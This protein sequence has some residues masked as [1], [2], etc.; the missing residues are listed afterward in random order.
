MQGLRSR[1]APDVF[2]KHVRI[3]IGNDYYYNYMLPKYQAQ[4][5]QATTIQLQNGQTEQQIG[6]SYKGAML[7]AAEA[8]QYGDNY[9]PVWYEDHTGASRKDSANQAFED[10]KKL[11]A[12]SASSQIMSADDKKKFQEWVSGYENVQQHVLDFKA[13]G[14]KHAAYLWENWW[15]TACTS[16]ATDPNLA[17][18]SY[19][20]STVL[21][22]MP[23]T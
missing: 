3:A 7:I 4:Y 11:L 8:K 12:S 9:N 2:L 23:G 15:F 14:N 18:Q 17:N 21:R 16:A 22:K 6:L 10:M 13:V 20:I 19:F 5:G 1:E